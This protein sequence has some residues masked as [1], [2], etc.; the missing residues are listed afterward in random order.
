LQIVN[1]RAI[2]LYQVQLVTEEARDKTKDKNIY[3]SRQSRNDRIVIKSDF[4][5]CADG[6]AIV[7]TLVCNASE[8]LNK[9]DNHAVKAAD[10]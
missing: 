3:H 2:L 4:S 8:A 6:V 7:V 9:K 10:S 1:K 5:F